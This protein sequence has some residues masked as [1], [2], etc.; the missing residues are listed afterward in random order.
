MTEYRD[1]EVQT[2]PAWLLDVFGEA[3]HFV[4]GLLKDGW[5]EATRD[6]VKARFAAIAPADAIPHLL[7]DFVLDDLYNETLAQ[8]RGRLAKAWS[9]W[10]KAGTK[11]GMLEAFADAG[12]T[13][14]DIQENVTAGRWWEFQVVLRP[15][16]P[17]D[18]ALATYWTWDGG[19]VWDGGAHWSGLAPIGERERVLAL[20]KKWKPKHARLKACLVQLSGPYWGEFAW[21]D[22]TL[23]G[24]TLETW[25]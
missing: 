18:H 25:E 5:V 9:L 16:F 12:Y 10:M 14:V 20:I 7:K 4:V 15:P 2:A 6:A 22:G 1:Y 23:W 8:T 17:W 13:T 19:A 24:G 3:Y 11:A 21:G